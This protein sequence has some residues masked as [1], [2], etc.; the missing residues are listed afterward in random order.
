[1][2]LTDGSCGMGTPWWRFREAMVTG[3][4]VGALKV[5]LSILLPLPPCYR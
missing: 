1:M 4:L 5:S 2:L 3:E